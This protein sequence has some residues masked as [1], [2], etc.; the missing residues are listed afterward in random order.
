MILAWNNRR[1]S[2]F[3]C[4]LALVLLSQPG[5][6]GPSPA[7]APTLLAGSADALNGLSLSVDFTPGSAGHGELLV[8]AHMVEPASQLRISLSM[9]PAVSLLDGSLESIHSILQ[10]TLV[11]SYPIEITEDGEFQVYVR[12]AASG[13]QRELTGSNMIALARDSSGRVFTLAQAPVV[14]GLLAEPLPMGGS[15]GSA[16]GRWQEVAPPQGEQATAQAPDPPETATALTVTGCFYYEDADGRNLGARNVWVRVWDDDILFNDLLWSGVARADGCWTAAGLTLEEESPSG[17]QD[18][19]VEYS[20]WSNPGGKVVDPFLGFYTTSTPVTS[21]VSSS[22]FDSGS[23]LPPADVNYRAAFRVFAYLEEAWQFDCAVGAGQDC[24]SEPTVEA[25]V[26][27]DETYY[28][29]GDNRIRVKVDGDS[30]RSRDVVAHERGHWVMDRLVY[31]DGFW[32]PGAGGDHTWCGQYTQG[33]A[34]TEG[35][36]TYYALRKGYWL[37]NSDIFFDYGSGGRVGIESGFACD[38]AVTGD[39][40][41]YRVA[42]ALWDIVDGAPDGKDAHTTS[43]SDLWFVVDDCVT[44]SFRELYDSPCSWVSHGLARPSLLFPAWQNYIDYN[45]APSVTVTFPNGGE[46][47]HGDVTVTAVTFDPD[48]EVVEVVFFWAQDPQVTSCIP[49]GVATTPSYSIEWNATLLPEGPGAYICAQAADGLEYS[50]VDFS[51]GPFGV[52]YT[53]PRSVAGLSG[54]VVRAGWYL[55]TVTVA[56]SATDAVSGIEVVEYSLDEA[57]WTA[58][59][60]ELLVSSDGP[61]VVLFRAR[62][63]AGNVEPVQAITFR[64]DSTPPS[65]RINAPHEGE[66]STSAT[67]TIQWSRDDLGS[68]M[69][70]CSVSI[71]GGNPAWVGN[72]TSHE[73]SNLAYGLHRVSVVCEDN[74]GNQER[75]LVSLNVDTSCLSPNGPCGPWLL[76]SIPIFGFAAS[77]SAALVLRQRRGS[78]RRRR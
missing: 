71:D 43:W 16:R 34:W 13:G 14:R 38:P 30:D 8:I 24:F 7:R 42:G 76:I 67:M 56:L 57:P 20:T 61:H 63:I 22:P 21:E 77:V 50:T 59:S 18:I 49:I 45:V 26:P 48:T 70:G 69:M 41:E 19:Y 9:P 5:L 53:S 1:A 31:E 68:G 28:Q 33:L 62:D 11:F 39:T 32:P 27:G 46:W 37:D 58:Y 78:D 65:V 75:A 2:I 6:S 47:L 4:S 10:E 52:D 36:A 55:S 51:D 25:I 44:P 29:I 54:W 40:N 3:A 17:N 15:N 73:F 35:W 72:E 66:V 74:A 60:R 12:A 64:I 23:W